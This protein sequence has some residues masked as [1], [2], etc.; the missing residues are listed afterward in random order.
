MKNKNHY[1]W[2]WVIVLIVGALVAW[3]VLEERG[4]VKPFLPRQENSGA[5][6][7]QE[8]GAFGS[9]MSPDGQWR[10]VVRETGDAR[11]TI[12]HTV[13]L[14]AVR[15]KNTRTLIS[16]EEKAKGSDMMVPGTNA[17]RSAGWSADGT[18][19]YYVTQPQYYGG[20]DW[21]PPETFGNKLFEVDVASKKSVQLISLNTSALLGEGYLDVYPQKDRVVYML[22]DELFLNRLGGGDK[23]PLQNPGVIRAMLN[24][25]ADKIAVGVIKNL[26]P[27]KGIEELQEGDIKDYYGVIDGKTGVYKQL[28]E[29]S[30]LKRWIDDKTL[31]VGDKKVK[32]G[33]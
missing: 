9:I 33:N 10:V 17:W 4:V 21:Q 20:F 27:Q 6:M 14:S 18:K 2:V 3:I 32:V 5:K 25:A 8:R 11:K 31:L 29:G 30:D 22:N 1:T 12:T 19:V 16:I 7:T 28:G 23:T 24:P 15:E 26:S 13:E